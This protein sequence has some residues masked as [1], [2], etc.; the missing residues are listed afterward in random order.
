MPNLQL[1]FQRNG[2][3]FD[4][5]KEG[6]EGRRLRKMIRTVVDADTSIRE[7]Q[8]IGIAPDHISL[9]MDPAGKTSNKTFNPL[10]QLQAQKSPPILSPSMSFDP[11]ESDN[12]THNAFSDNML[13]SLTEAQSAQRR[14]PNNARE[15]TNGKTHVTSSNRQ[16]TAKQAQDISPQLSPALLQSRMPNGPA[17]ASAVAPPQSRYFGHRRAKNAYEG[18]RSPFELSAR[19]PSSE[20]PTSAKEHRGFMNKFLRRGTRKEDALGSPDEPC[21]TFAFESLGTSEHAASSGHTEGAF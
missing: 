13:K 8:D 4:K 21:P 5:D 19:T 7:A 14:S 15:M 10:P 16:E 17:S 3:P 1:E 11:Q 18:A 9:E 6:R 2:K 12:T 20:A